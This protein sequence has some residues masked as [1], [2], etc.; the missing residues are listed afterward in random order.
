MQHTVDKPVS[1]SENERTCAQT[2]APW[3]VDA[4]PGAEEEG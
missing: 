2:K 1:D 3:A 4:L